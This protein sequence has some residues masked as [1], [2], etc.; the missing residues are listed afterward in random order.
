MT[1][2]PAMIPGVEKVFVCTDMTINP[3]RRPPSNASCQLL[4][5]TSSIDH[6]EQ[7]AA[8]LEDPHLPEPDNARLEELFGRVAEYA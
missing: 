3:L 7:N 4:T 8:A 1:L 6:L 2:Q 5:G